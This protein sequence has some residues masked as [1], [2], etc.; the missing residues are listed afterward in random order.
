M[1]FGAH[2]RKVRE[3]KGI[4]QVTL[5]TQAGVSQSYIC[6]IELESNYPA[7]SENCIRRIA[8]ALNVNENELILKAGQVPSGLKAVMKNNPSLTRLVRILSEQP[9][10]DIVY[11]DM[12]Y[13]AR[14]A[15][16]EQ[17]A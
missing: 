7:P 15:Q 5:A 3:S 9:L 2:V 10:P 12:L 6:K 4:S 11:K 16:E 8:Q 14:K 1:K 13:L 17:S